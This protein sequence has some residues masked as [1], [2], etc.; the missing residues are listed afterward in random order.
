M[1]C[2][3]CHDLLI[4]YLYGELDDTQR[5]AF[6]AALA[7]C[8]ECA[9]E[10][11]ALKQLQATADLAPYA[12]LTDAQRAHVLAAARDAAALRALPPVVPLF[13]RPGFQT[14]IAAAFAIGIASW[15]FLRSDQVLE[16][17]SDFPPPASSEVARVFLEEPETPKPRT[18]AAPNAAPTMAQADVAD[19]ANHDQADVEAQAREIQ[20]TAGKEEREIAA[21]PPLAAPSAA[22]P[23]DGRIQAAPAENLDAM[24]ATARAESPMAESAA[25][26][27]PS[28]VDD[29]PSFHDDAV[30]VAR[31]DASM[32]A[33][34]RAVASGGSAAPYNGAAS[35]RGAAPAASGAAI[36]EEPAAAAIQ[37][38]APFKPEVVEMARL[39][40]EQASPTPKE[41]IQSEALAPNLSEPLSVA[42]G[43]E[44]E[45]TPD[46]ALADA[47]QAWEANEFDEAYRRFTELEQRSP[48][49][50]RSDAVSVYRAADAARRTKHPRQLERWGRLYLETWP[51]GRNAD[52]LRTWLD[53]PPSTAPP[54]TDD[55]AP[56]TDEPVRG[57][58]RTTPYD[59]GIRDAE[60][61]NAEENSDDASSAPPKRH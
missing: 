46:E 34:S 61:S 51:L 59:P 20:N 42:Q 16:R 43:Y 24:R 60:P 57:N 10:L 44:E 49:T 19:E 54:E 39:D 2:A 27:E 29:A 21:A 11:E 40:M 30:A 28:Q 22:A 13:R 31:V 8:P 56:D 47:N 48:A 58:L 36:A 14:A 6:E 50:F 41:S 12:E 9:A 38:R 15:M 35:A 3:T 53:V 1:N 32:A 5:P 18:T 37:A 55:E 52:E 4:D 26:P 7:Q 17:A 25:P 33:R 23:L 45:A